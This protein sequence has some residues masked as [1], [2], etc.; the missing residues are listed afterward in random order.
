MIDIDVYYLN[1]SNLIEKIDDFFSSEEDNTFQFN[2]IEISLLNKCEQKTNEI[3]IFEEED[4]YVNSV[5]IYEKVISCY[6]N[7]PA[8]IIVSSNKEIFNVVRW[9]R[10]GAADYLLLNEIKK[11][12]FI[13]SIRGSVSFVTNKLV[14][15]NEEIV[16]E[17]YS[18]GRIMLPKDYDWNSLTNDQFYDMSLVMI[19]LVLEKDSIGRYS[20]ASI[21]KIFEQVKNEISSIMQ[22]FGGRIWLWQNNWGI[23]TFHFGDIVNCSVLSSVYLFNHFFLVCLEKLKLEE[24]IKLKI[25][26]HSGNCLFHKTNTEQITSD[27]INSLVHLEKQYT[28]EDSLVITDEV[29]KNLSARLTPAFVKIGEYESREIFQYTPKNTYTNN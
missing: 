4:S 22:I 10:K 3:L 17:S 7:K 25:S 18:K 1:N 21:E 19:N 12:I 8:I 11:D 27:L 15:P 26:I 23:I 9:M 6:E 2:F 20:K 16:D 24:I 28:Q 14:I 13:N 5:D 29:Y